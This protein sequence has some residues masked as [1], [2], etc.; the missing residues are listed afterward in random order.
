MSLC[1]TI[2]CRDALFGRAPALRD[3]FFV[4]LAPRSERL[5]IQAQWRAWWRAN[6]NAVRRALGQSKFK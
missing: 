4:S 2:V 3:F 6:E 1:T 5:Q